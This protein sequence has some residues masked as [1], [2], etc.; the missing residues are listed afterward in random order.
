MR[1][2]V[3]LDTGPL[4]ALL[5]RR[6]RHHQWAK[7]H[8]A[9]IAPPLLTCESV[10]A[11]A[12][13]LAQPFSGG[14]TAV[15][16]MVRRSVLDLSFRLAEESSAVVRL[17]KKYQDV[18]MSLADGCLVRMAEQHPES[19]VFTLDSGFKIYRKCRRQQIPTLSP[20]I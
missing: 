4:V 20:T 14:Q 5:N 1:N 11:E 17:L 12:C 8:W 16:E 9:E 6:D 13:I 10:L 18:P 2:K 7:D 3:I 15:L 19:V